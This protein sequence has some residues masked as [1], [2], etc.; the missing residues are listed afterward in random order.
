MASEL[1]PDNYQDFLANLKEHIRTAQAKAALAVNREL[2]MLY[3]HI[4]HEIW[5][6]QLEQGWGAK[7]INRLSQDLRVAFPD[8]KGF[9][10]R[11]LQYMRTFAEAWPDEEFTQRVVARI[12]WAHNVR[13]LDSIRNPAEREWYIN[14]T[15]EQGWS[16]DIL[17]LQ[18]ESKLYQRQG[19]AE[20]NFTQTL[21]SSQSDLVQQMLKD[22]YNFDFLGLGNEA[23]EREVHRGLVEHIRE[24]LI[25]L[26]SGFA[27]VGSQY[28]LEVSGD[29]YYLDL[30]FYHLKLRRYIVIDLK[31]AE[32]KPEYVGKMNFYLSAVDDL[33]RHPNDEPSI[34]L[35]L[36][37]SKDRVKAEYAL[38]G[39]TTPIGIAEYETKLTKALPENLKGNLPTIEELEAELDTIAENK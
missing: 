33:L 8:M 23:Q 2:V 6:R 14:Q 12:P 27:F 4:G 16:R 20:T 32:F 1:L 10:T 25:E 24:F 34:G 29:D 5:K 3:W 22:P 28:H 7:V 13:I 11:N 37:R 39:V 35:I 26:G 36:S 30:L 18:I 15:V 17:A 21:P 31:S 38:R 9:S 19:K